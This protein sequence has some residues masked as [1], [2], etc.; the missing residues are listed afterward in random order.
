MKKLTAVIL[1]YG[2]RGSIYGRYALEQPQQL[3]IVAVADSL[4]TKRE[5]A[6]EHFG[7]PEQR[8]FSDWHRLADCDRLA[9]F[10]IVTLQDSL[11]YEAA[12][13]LIDKGYHLLLEKPMGVTP[14]QCKAITEAAEKRGVQVVVCHVLRFTRFWQGIKEVLDAGTLGEV[15][16]VIHMENVG[17][18]HQSHSFVR[19]N[20]RNAAESTPMILAKCC[21][22]MD[23]LQ[24]LIGKDCKRVQSFG[25]LTHFTKENRPEGAP[26][27]CLMG[28]PA[29]STCPYQVQ[30]VYM[31]NKDDGFTRILRSVVANT[32]EPPED[33]AVMEALRTGPYGRCVYACDN[34][35]VDHQVVNLE[36]EGGCTVSFTMNAFNYGGRFIRIFGTKGELVGDMEACTLQL[37]SFADCSWSAV[38][39]QKVGQGIEAGHGGGDTGIMQDFLRLL[40]GE[41]CGKGICQVRTSYKNHLIA[42]AAERSRVEGTVISLQ[43]YAEK[44]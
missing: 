33:A 7:L 38:K 12:L 18:V 37:Y 13:A 40:R 22:D 44:L 14:A 4:E 24:W 9:D 21:H 3:Q 34:D 8:V 29:E 35:V 2:G 41:D 23:I 1:G 26:E 19:G 43:E 5:Q 31:Q 27:R 20:W 30:R 25:S 32:T 15:M 36:F 16:S 42:F 10:A 39:L 28:C 17:N 6:R 11:H